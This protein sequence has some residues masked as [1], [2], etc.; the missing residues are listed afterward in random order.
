[1]EKRNVWNSE[2]IINAIKEKKIQ[3]NIKSLSSIKNYIK[4]LREII[5]IVWRIGEKKYCTAKNFNEKVGENVSW[6]LYENGTL[7]LS[8]QDCRRL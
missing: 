7:F 3:G 2:N 6:I 4:N 5:A 8:V 1:M